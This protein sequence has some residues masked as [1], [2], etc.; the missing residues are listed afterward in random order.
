VSVLGLYAT[1][2]VTDKLSLN[3]RGEWVHADIEYASSYTYFGDTT[4]RGSSSSS[5]SLDAYELTGTVEYDMWANVISRLEVRWD[6]V[7]TPRTLEQRSGLGLYA[8]VIYK[9]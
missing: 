9:F 5:Q 7:S 6:H 2:K 3:A 4:V 8:N 1:Y